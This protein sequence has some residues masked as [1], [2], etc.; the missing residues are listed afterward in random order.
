[1]ISWPACDPGTPASPPVN[2]VT[3]AVLDTGI[4]RK[5]PDLRNVPLIGYNAINASGQEVGP[6]LDSAVGPVTA[7]DDDFGHGTY[8][9]GI[10]AA[11]WNVS[12]PES[13]STSCVG[14]SPT[15]G[16][17]GLAPGV[18]LMAVKVLDET[19]YGTSESIALGTDYA[20]S[21]GARVLNFS[22]GGSGQDPIEQTAIEAALAAGCVV[23]AASGNDSDLPNSQS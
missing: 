9:S 6:S 1:L 12:N 7:T 5:H 2:A 19:G 15:K 11:Q 21:H 13:G 4:S 14:G 20:V 16:M 22:L 23:V 10:L 17:A 8:V 3:V 18:T